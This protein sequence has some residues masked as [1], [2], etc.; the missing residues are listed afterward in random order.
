MDLLSLILGPANIW[1]QGIVSKLLWLVMGEQC[2]DSTSANLSLLC[3]VF[4]RSL[5]PPWESFTI[6]S[7]Q[8]S[9]ARPSKAPPFR[10]SHGSVRYLAIH[11]VIIPQILHLPRSWTITTG[12]CVASKH[13]FLVG[14]E[15]LSLCST[16]SPVTPY[17]LQS[18]IR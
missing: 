10:G 9:S 6:S 15:W 3:A 12:H 16:I 17:C 8:L 4:I 2:L 11:C 7:A 5:F 13:E 14:R 1:G 18:L